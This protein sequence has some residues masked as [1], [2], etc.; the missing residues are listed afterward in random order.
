MRKLLIAVLAVLAF[1]GCAVTSE[2]Y[3]YQTRFDKFY[4]LLNDEE[5]VLFAANDMRGVGQ[6]LARRQ[7][8][9][10]DLSNAM[11]AVEDYEAI[12]SFSD[13]QTAG[14]FRNVILKELNW[15]NY[16]RFLKSFT[17]QELTLF[18]NGAGFDPVVEARYQSDRK[19]R[20]FMDDLRKEYRFYGF[21]NQQIVHFFRMIS[22]PEA[23]GK[24]LYW[25]LE[26]MKKALVLE[27]FRAGN[28]AEAARKLSAGGKGNLGAFDVVEIR[29]LTGLENMD[30]ALFLDTY[31]RVVIPQMDAE[32]VE[33]IWM[34]F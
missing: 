18:A 3:R 6:S 34:K 16:Y 17:G 14:F 27:D 30:M 13:E 15:P 31:A 23:A 33:K 25:L 11:K 21:S 1:S 7:A 20:A 32:A 2:K 29:K 10:R 22:F 28:V 4:H 19:F 12:T 24:Q 8:A 5:K 9:D 26:A